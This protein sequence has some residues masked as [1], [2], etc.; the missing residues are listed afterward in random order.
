M[1]IQCISKT[2]SVAANGAVSATNYYKHLQFSRDGTTIVAQRADT[3]L[4][5][6]VLPTDLL[7]SE[8]G[9][10][11]SY[12]N[13]IAPSSLQSFDI[14]PGYSLQDTNTTW[15]LSSCTDLPIQLRNALNYDYTTIAYPWISPT[16]EQYHAANS[17]LFVAEGTHFAAGA[18][19]RLAL[20][21]ISRPNEEPA[22]IHHRSSESYSEGLQDKGLVMALAESSPGGML[23][24]GTTN[25][26][27]ILFG[28]S[29]LGQAAS[30]F[31]LASSRDDVCSGTGITSLV[32]SPCERY[33]IIAERQSECA[34]VFDIRKGGERLAWLSGRAAQSTQRFDLDLVRTPE[35][36]EV[37]SGGIDGH[38]KMWDNPGT[39]E[40]EHQAAIDMAISDQPIGSA[41]WH[42]SGSILATCAGGRPPQHTKSHT[43]AGKPAATSERNSLCIWQPYGALKDD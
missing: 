28:A 19:G 43:K 30:H 39:V 14:H 6:F 16:T 40:G 8:D 5:T 26:T 11:Q 22:T 31:P 15:V 36:C 32:W 10:L 33:L 17:L 24:A 29:G 41:R 35:G 23:A 27:V 18:K 12:C 7:E 9:L 4:D 1:H 20:F 42:H 25:R 13:G 2:S 34:Q 38:V 21:D 3:S 37:W